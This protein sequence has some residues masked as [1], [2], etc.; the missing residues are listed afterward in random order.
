VLTPLE[1]F[2]DNLL[3]TADH[4]VKVQ[5]NMD[6]PIGYLDI[7]EG[8]AE[9][10]LPEAFPRRLAYPG[11]F[12]F[13]LLWRGGSKLSLRVCIALETKAQA[14]GQA[15]TKGEQALALAS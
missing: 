8:V 9:F 3:P 6:A 1:Q 10:K 11:N 14:I 2:I 15:G 4:G 7:K 12:L 13:D 5:R